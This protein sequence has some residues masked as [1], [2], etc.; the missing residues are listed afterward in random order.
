MGDDTY[1]HGAQPGQRLRSA[2]LFRSLDQAGLARAAGV[3]PSVVC[4]IE[5]SHGFPS[6]I[7]LMKLAHA[8]G[9][10]TDYLLGRSAD[11]RIPDCPPRK[12]DALERDSRQL[13][14]T[15]RRLVADL[16]ASLGDADRRV[17]RQEAM[18]AHLQRA[19]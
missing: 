2:R 10:A 13:S 1:V 5:G 14:L 9:V 11:A 12:V 8:M 3:N 18:I 6:V 15:H 19:G 4:R 7:T 17:K 16:V